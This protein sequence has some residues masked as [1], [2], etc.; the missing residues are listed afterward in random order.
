MD[1]TAGFLTGAV[2]WTAGFLT[3]GACRRAVVPSCRPGD[4]AA[5]RDGLG[6][7]LPLRRADPFGRAVPGAPS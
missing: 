7:G 5:L 2:D 1:G 6:G 3:G 4:P